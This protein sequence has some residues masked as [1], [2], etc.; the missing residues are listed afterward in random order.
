[1]Y[2]DRSKNKGRETVRTEKEI[3]IM[4]NLVKS[5]CEDFAFNPHLKEIEEAKKR[6]LEWVLE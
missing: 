4:L 6:T 2:R 1:M 3:Q 5:D